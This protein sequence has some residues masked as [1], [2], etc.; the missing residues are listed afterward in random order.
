MNAFTRFVSLGLRDADTRVATALAPP[1]LEQTDR[2]LRNSAL[3]SAIDRVTVRLHDWWS[4]SEVARLSRTAGDTFAGSGVAQR[5]RSIATVVLASV[6]V[7]VA[8]T[9]IQGPRPGW[10]WLIIPAM[11][12]VFAVSVLA[13]TSG[14]KR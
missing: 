13:T 14:T 12:A 3:V 7:H 10:F 5:Y 4:A 11:G 8:L 6:V 9:L 1:P 2:Y